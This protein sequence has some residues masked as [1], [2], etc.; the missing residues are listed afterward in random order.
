MRE[1]AAPFPR[2]PADRPFFLLTT[3]KPSTSSTRVP[4]T[5]TQTQQDKD[6]ALLSSLGG[7]SGLAARLC[8]PPDSGPA[9]V[10]ASVA[11][12]PSIDARR[13]AFGANKFKEVAS[14]SFIRLFFESLKDPILVLLMAAALVSTVLGAAIPEE[15]EQAAWSEGIAI[16]VAVLVVSLVSSGNDYQ[17][18]LQ[19]RK[20]NAQKEKVMIKVLRGGV[21][22]LVLNTELVVGDVVRLI[23][24]ELK[25]FPFFLVWGS[26]REREREREREKKKDRKNSPPL[27]FSLP[28]S[29]GDKVAADGVVLASQGLVI[30]EAS[31]TGESDPIKKSSDK[32]PWVR[33]GTQVSEGSGS[34]LVTAVGV[35]SEW[36]RTMALVVGEA[37]DTPLQ[38]ALTVLAQAVGKVGLGVGVVCFVVLLIRWI[39]EN[40][41]FPLAQFSEG[42]LRFFIFSITIIVVAV[43][44]GLPL[45]VTISL[46][47]SMRKMMKDNNFVRVLAACETMGGATAICSDKTGTLTENRMTVVAAKLGGAAAPLERPPPQSREAVAGG[48]EALISDLELNC[49]LNSKAFL[50]EK[51]E[52]AEAAAGTTANGGSKS[53]TSSSAGAASSSASASSTSGPTIEFVGNRTECAL[54]MMLR[55]W[56]PKS[57]YR[58]LRAAHAPR[59]LREYDFS[60]LRKMASVL[61]APLGKTD[62]SAGA[63]LYVKG[64]AEMVVSRCV[65]TYVSGGGGSSVAPLDD[66]GRARLIDEVTAMAAT[67]LRTIALAQRDLSAAALSGGAPEVPPEEQLMLV[68]IVGI[69]DPVRKEVPDAVATCQR[70]G[71]TVS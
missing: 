64:A 48:D 35:H 39:V 27:L 63:R 58:A 46:A 34:M 23:T 67:G 12:T 21:D 11:T 40:R 43:P 37:G 38:Q 28:L 49:A 5:T 29:P 42:P 15:R 4:P 54:L 1:R 44:E 19:F 53:K 68:G 62:A 59:V 45:A 71:I 52:T 16:W 51:V 6:N 33:C 60:S 47:Y 22:M 13:A 41:G 3:S 24:G 30:D 26:T 8:T 9:L 56:G 70:A 2:A 65:S 25:F 32:D 18:D 55:G 10:P 50:I 14:K 66:A 31:L 7:P 61:V 69:K 36:G 57:D 20:L 17:K